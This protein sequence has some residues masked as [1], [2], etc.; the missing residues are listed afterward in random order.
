MEIFVSNKLLNRTMRKLLYSLPIFVGAILNAVASFGQASL[1][2]DFT[3]LSVKRMAPKASCWDDP[4]EYSIFI[5][6]GKEDYS[7][8]GGDSNVAYKYGFLLSRDQLSY[9]KSQLQRQNSCFIPNIA[10]RT[11]SPF[12]AFR[13]DEQDN[14]DVEL[15][16]WVHNK[17]IADG[18][19][20]NIYSYC[21]SKL[22][23]DNYS[24]HKIMGSFQLCKKNNMYWLI[25]G[26]PMNLGGKPVPWD[27]SKNTY[28]AIDEIAIELPSALCQKLFFQ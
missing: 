5:I 9:V 10:I 20:R 7:S 24:S 27:V 26:E 2:S 6:D 4:S 23:P 8:V 12:G 1:D 21:E 28:E 11:M 14:D 22:C 15:S 13:T 16:L 17:T 18:T 19:Y 3:L 25:V